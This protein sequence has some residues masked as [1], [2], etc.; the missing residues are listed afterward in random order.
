MCVRVFTPS[1]E[2][3][4]TQGHF[5]AEFNWFDLKVFLLQ[6]QLPYQS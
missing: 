1:H 4:D 2:Q 3:N 5:K 6:D